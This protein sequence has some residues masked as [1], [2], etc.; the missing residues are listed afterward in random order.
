M[1][2]LY[3]RY[4]LIIKIEFHYGLAVHEIFLYFMGVESAKGRLT[5]QRPGAFYIDYFLFN[6][7]YCI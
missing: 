6:I 1:P 3:L 4:E 2:L 5:A 7:D